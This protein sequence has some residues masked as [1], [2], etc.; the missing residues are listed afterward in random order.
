MIRGLAQRFHQDR[1]RHGWQ[2]TLRAWRMQLFRRLCGFTI[3]QGLKV[4]NIEPDNERF[5]GAFAAFHCSFVSSHLLESLANDPLYEIDPDFV[6]Q[7]LAKGDDCFG[8]FEGQKLAAYSWY[9]SQPTLAED[10][11]QVQCSKKYVYMYKAFTHPAYRG[12]HLNGFGVSQA[13]RAY[14]GLGFKGMI[15]YV[16]PQNLASLKSLGRL[17]CKP[18]GSVAYFRGLRRVFHSSGCYDLGFAATPS[19][20]QT[21]V[22]DREL[23]KVLQ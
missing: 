1:R 16:H 2:L 20:Q 11:W 22:G 13:V 15:C 21:R 23:E 7:A 4:T 12:R 8:V 9:S 6:R 19:R 18:F 5:S 3:L 14:L 17:G 10:G